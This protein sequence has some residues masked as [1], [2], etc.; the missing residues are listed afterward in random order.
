MARDSKEKGRGKDSGKRPE[1]E[2]SQFSTIDA[3]HELAKYNARHTDT[4]EGLTEWLKSWWS[5]QYN[6]PL[7]DPLLLSYTLHELLYEYHDK[8]E[9]AIAADEAIELNTDKI[10]EAQEREAIDWAEEEERKEREVAEAEQK[11]KDDQ[12]MLEQMKKEH[13]EDF[14]KDIE[15]DFE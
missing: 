9:R 7:K 4:E 2:L 1:G 6:R 10:E 15:S 11:A 14:G 8:N 5:K 13:G 3:V 12:W